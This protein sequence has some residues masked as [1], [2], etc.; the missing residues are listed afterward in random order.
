MIKKAIWLMDNLI[1]FGSE[2][3]AKVWTMQDERDIP[4]G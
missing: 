3:D 2:N 1:G 4:L